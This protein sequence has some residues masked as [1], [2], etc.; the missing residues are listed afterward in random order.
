M[1]MATVST[2]SGAALPAGLRAP[3]LWVVQSGQAWFDDSPGHQSG[4]GSL[5]LTGQGGPKWG[6]DSIV[7]VVVELV[8]SA[9]VHVLLAARNCP[10]QRIM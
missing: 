5:L 2:T 6:P 10:I 4:A 3:S 8:S 1:A 9:G 7:D